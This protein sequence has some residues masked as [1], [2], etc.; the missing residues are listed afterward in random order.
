MHVMPHQVPFDNL[1]FLAPPYISHNCRR[2]TP[3]IRFSL[4]FVKTLRDIRSPFSDDSGCDILSC[5]NALLL[6]EIEDS[7]PSVGHVK[8]R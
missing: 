5:V 3:K 7:P 1:R 4:R 2:S 6:A 8:L